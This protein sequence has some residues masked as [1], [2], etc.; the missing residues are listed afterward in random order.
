MRQPSESS[1]NATIWDSTTFYRTP[2]LKNNPL[3]RPRSCQNKECQKV[4]RISNLPDPIIQHI[5]SF[6]PADDAIKTCI[7]SKR[8]D[9]IWTLVPNLIFRRE[10]SC[11]QEAE[12]FAVFVDKALM[13]YRSPK[14]KKFLVE[15]EFTECFKAQVDSWVDFAVRLKVE[16]L[17]L[18]FHREIAD[19][20]DY[21]CLPNFLYGNIPAEKLSLRF[22]ALSPNKLK[23]VSW[24]SLKVLSISYGWLSNEMIKN[25]CLGCSLLEYLKLNQCYGFDQIN[26]N[27]SSSLKDLVVDGSWGPEDKFGDFVITIKG[28]NLLSLTLA[29]YMHRANYMLLDVSSLVEANIG[30]RMKSCSHGCRS[31]WYSAHRSVLHDLLEKLQHVE[32]L[33]I[34]TWCLQVL[35]ISEVKGLSS[36][37]SACKY[38]TL[39]KKINKW[40]LPGIASLLQSSPNLQKLTINLMPSNN[41]E[42]ELDRSFYKYYS[43]DGEEYWSLYNQ[44]IFKCLVL[45]L[46]SVE[47]FG[48]DTSCSSL[49]LVVDQWVQFLLKNAK[50]LEKM[51]IHAQRDD[52]NRT[53]MSVEAQEL[54]ELL[55]LTQ[56]F[57]SYPRASP[58]AKVMLESCFK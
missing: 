4:D 41:F 9:S 33:T 5:L 18:E 54:M 50:V 25:I 31:N 20:P 42:F 21:Y 11:S 43:F 57:L 23:Q 17:C 2:N 29:G 16:E 47:I 40:D 44:R 22:C 51:I 10:C 34:G 53:W 26:T 13:H 49:K 56:A 14:V 58:N 24:M 1:V 6:L 48:F 32:K 3:K 38:L 52:V 55:E 46:K 39:N 12:N 37:T 28:P 35:S 45:H 19:D 7:L 8:W 27:F 30:Y 15:F 36:P